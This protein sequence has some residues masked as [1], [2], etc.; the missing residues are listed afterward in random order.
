VTDRALRELVLEVRQLRAELAEQRAELAFLLRAVLSRQDRRAGSALVPLLAEAFNGE[1]FTAAEIA[2]SALN[3]RD[4]ASQA[5]RE[6]VADYC[7]AEGGLRAL[8]RL[9]ARLEGCSFDGGRLV[10]G[11]ERRGVASWRISGA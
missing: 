4:A 2:T 5:L 7:T 9:L 10:S 8:G 6:L 3:G 11:G 1:C